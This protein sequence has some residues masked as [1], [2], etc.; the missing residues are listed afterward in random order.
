MPP[1]DKTS[2]YQTRLRRLLRYTWPIPLAGLA[3]AVL[4]LAFPLPKEK[5]HRPSSTLI[6]DRNDQL[7]RAFTA[8]DDIWRMPCDR[9]E[10]PSLL[11]DMVTAYED[12]WFR[13]HPGVNPV[14]IVRAAIGNIRAGEIVSGGSTLT[15]QIARMMEPKERTIA[16]KLVEMFRAVQLELLYSKDELL[17]LYFNLA[18]YGG[19]IEGITSAARLYFGKPVGTL[20]VGEIALLTA[21]P[22]SPTELRP[23][24]HP[25]RARRARE[26]VLRR[27]M[28]NGTI[29]VRQY[30]DA[31][32]EPIP[33]DRQRLPFRAPHL[34]RLL[35]DTHPDQPR[36]TTTIDLRTQEICTNLLRRHIAPLRSKDISNGAVVVIHNRTH[37][38]RAMVGSADFFEETSSGQ[39]N[40]A[41]APRSP[42]S[43]LKPFV[44]AAALDQ[45]LISE[46]SMLEDVPVDFSGYRPVNY[47]ETCHG[48]VTARQA[49]MHS[50]NVPAINLC[51][52]LTEK[53]IYPLLKKARLST[54]T[55]SQEL[56]GLP[57][58][59]GACE[60]NLL[61]LTNLYAALANEGLHVPYRLLMDE[62]V[63]DGRR[64]FSEAAAY[65]V[66]EILTEV[67]RP[68]LPSCWESARN[69]PKVAWKT[70]TSYGHR[71]AWSI[72]YNPEYT[73]G[74]WVG[75]F[76]GRGAPAL[77][78]AEA[79]APLLFDVFNA[80]S[81]NGTQA[82]F[83]QPS[84]VDTRPVCAL[85]G[86]PASEIC[87]TTREEL[88][89]PGTSPW[90][91]CSVH[92]HIAVDDQT[93]HRLCPHCR[94]GRPHHV[95]IV[96][97]W[98][99]KLAT[100]MARNGHP[101]DEIPSHYPGCGSRIAGRG[102]IIRSPSTNCDYLLRE[103][104]D[105]RYQQILLDASVPNTVEQIYWF[106]DGELLHTCPPEQQ[107]FY[108][109]APG[110][111]TL[112]CMDDLG[113]SSKMTLWVRQ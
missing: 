80:L 100:W 8:H 86:M 83:E 21:L 102:P 48:I 107:V 113:R 93:G 59:L 45:G 78:G 15:M 64:L 49:L 38:V 33:S 2:P 44:Y 4:C 40:G 41:R 27:L 10:I 105:T 88:H 28:E 89:I 37:E 35:R 1:R 90:A 26:K 31:S 50:L 108:T 5:L 96:A 43:A 11:V 67:E 101:V 106:L 70:G 65:V 110:R 97:Q 55:R 42:G 3:F 109:P 29:S 73:I 36:L 22:R 6:Y 81:G 16:A 13:R 63:R 32:S 66:T 112:L 14:S 82:W 46:R 12:R 61:E 75:N 39:V 69:L 56:Y 68:D 30:S 74:V 23:D 104:V 25:D 51:A 19:N 76:S 58:I 77:V 9:D 111:H 7:L 92:R 54:L 47:D 60:V 91:T 72:G 85:S 18:P 98:P 99:P 103:G 79:A 34:S 17:E 20:S 62:S 57:I 84:T 87:P 94:Q 71:D 24:A 53:S 52:A 95:E